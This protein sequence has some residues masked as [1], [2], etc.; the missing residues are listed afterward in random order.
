MHGW[1]AACL[2]GRSDPNATCSSEVE[3]HR[4]QC[5]HTEDDL[6][7]S[8]VIVQS[9]TAISCIYAYLHHICSAFLLNAVMAAPS[10]RFLEKM[11]LDPGATFDAKKD[12]Q[13]LLQE[14]TVYRDRLN[15]LYRL[16]NN[17]VRP[18]LLGETDDPHDCNVIDMVP[19]LGLTTCQE[20]GLALKRLKRALS[21]DDSPKH[22]NDNVLP[23]LALLG[24][25]ELCSG[26]CR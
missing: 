25:D 5:F 3:H 11:I 1:P 19:N 2:S 8:E 13:R 16:M 9:C 21:A 23:F 12:G 4:C 18:I 7:E 15:L 26:T 17:R 6:K 24:S 10:F 22:V 14:A 20:D